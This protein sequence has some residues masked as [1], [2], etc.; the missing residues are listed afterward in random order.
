MR[1]DFIRR[2]CSRRGCLFCSWL[3]RRV[4]CSLHGHNAINVAWE[5][6]GGGVTISYSDELVYHGITASASGDWWLSYLTY[7]IGNPNQL[8]Q[9]VV[10]RTPG[11]AYAGATV[12]TYLDPTGWYYHPSPGFRCSGGSCFVFGD[13]NRP[14]SDTSA[15]SSVPMVSRSAY[16]NDISQ[17]FLQDPPA[18][19]VPQFLPNITPFKVG[20]DIRPLGPITPDLMRI[21]TAI[22]SQLDAS[23]TWYLIQVPTLKRKP[24]GSGICCEARSEPCSRLQYR[25]QTTFRPY[26][27]A[28]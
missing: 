13:Y 24:S 4:P 22:A 20:S 16:V 9:G 18:G 12:L 19:N 25:S 2:F 10:Y 11:G 27:M 26:Q 14:T 15:Q 8:Q 28:R 3:G 23:L 7:Q 17:L 5:A 21:W 1:A 6:N